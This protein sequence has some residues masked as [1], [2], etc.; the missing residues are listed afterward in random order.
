MFLLALAFIGTALAQEKYPA[1]PIK[2]IIPLG[3][4]S[5]N[6]V[7]TRVLSESL[8][9]EL[10][11]QI[12][13]EYKAGGGGGVVGSDFVAKSK[14]DGYTIG[15]LNNSVFTISPVFTPVPYDPLKDFSPIAR[16]GVGTGR[17]G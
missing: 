4:G 15:T 7:V 10:K 1:K 11:T 5:G 14:P 2:I 9:K 8:E 3:P 12:S 13:V 6:D 17:L 16:L